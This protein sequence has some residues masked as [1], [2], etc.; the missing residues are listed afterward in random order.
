VREM[1]MARW[2]EKHGAGDMVRLRLKCSLS[3]F[4]SNRDQGKS[5]RN[6]TMTS[7]KHRTVSLG[8]QFQVL[9]I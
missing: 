4:A 6:T 7:D 8:I 2:R 5:E 9:R 3:D 1:V